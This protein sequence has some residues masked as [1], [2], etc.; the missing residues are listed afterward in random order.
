[1]HAGRVGVP[2]RE[3]ASRWGVA[4][5]GGGCSG[6]SLLASNLFAGGFPPTRWRWSLVVSS[7]PIWNSHSRTPD[8]RFVSPHVSP[9]GFLLPPE[10]EVTRTSTLSLDN[11]PPKAKRM[12]SRAAAYVRSSKA[13]HCELPLAFPHPLPALA[14]PTFHR[15]RAKLVSSLR[16]SG[17]PPT[18]FSAPIPSEA[19]SLAS[20]SPHHHHQRSSPSRHRLPFCRALVTLAPGASRRVESSTR[21]TEL[22]ACD[23]SR[24]QRH[25]QFSKHRDPD[26][27]LPIE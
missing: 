4:G 10:L 21:T 26:R 25:V 27:R 15:S 20:F 17:S 24:R 18:S 11:P 8:V 3:G 23:R 13:V 1:M 9:P 6:I 5:T 12:H 19:S 7:P 22:A 16:T 2:R 14:T